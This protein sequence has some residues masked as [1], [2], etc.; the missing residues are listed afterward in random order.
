[1]QTSVNAA[2]AEILKNLSIAELNDMQTAV[3]EKAS[4]SDNLMLLAPTG[5]GKTLAFLIPLVNKL[6]ADAAGVQA[7]IVA[8]SRELSLQIEQVFRAMKTSFKVT[9]CY[10]GHAMSVEQNYHRHTRPIGRPH[11]Q[12]VI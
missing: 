7:L 9:C 10:G 6:R 12:K 4:S 11:F 2:N 3:I 1:M 8:P 5:S